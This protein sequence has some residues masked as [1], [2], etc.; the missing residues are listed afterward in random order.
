MNKEIG[1]GIL[2]LYT[3]EDVNKCWESIPDHYKKHD[4]SIARVFIASNNN[5]KSISGTQTRQYTTQVPMA[6]MRNHLISEMRLVGCKYY[7][8]IHSN[9]I[10][11]DPNIFE[12]TIKLAETFGTWVIFG[13]S[14][15][16]TSIE[17]DN[18]LTLN[19]SKHLNDEFMF[20]Y[21]GIIKNNGYFDERYFNG[22]NLDV[23]D[24][25][26]KLRKKNVYPPEGYHPTITSGVEFGIGNINKIGFKDIPDI[27][28]D[29]QMSYGWFMNNHKFI[30]THNDPTPVSET[31]LLS[32]METIQKNYGKK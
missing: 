18:G 20:I 2:D 16:N 22:K 7:F 19:L 14:I 26:I 29:V 6:T 25:I 4:D 23:L 10:I 30:P 17:D 3:Q 27:S 5:N 32:S 1:I 24:Y 11:D 13:N 28:K 15:D 12:N 8:L 21:S 9:V 31:D